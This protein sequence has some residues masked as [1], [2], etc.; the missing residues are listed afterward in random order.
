MSV[1]FAGCKWKIV[2]GATTASLL[3]KVTEGIFLAMI[4]ILY[5]KTQEL[6]QN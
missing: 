2:V 4:I 3:E 5:L 6:E 1:I